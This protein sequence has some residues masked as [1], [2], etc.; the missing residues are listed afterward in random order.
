M[1]I[2]G[3][4]VFAGALG[5]IAILGSKASKAARK[6]KIKQDMALYEEIMKEKENR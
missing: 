3:L 1:I 5:L 6:A 2:L 4:F